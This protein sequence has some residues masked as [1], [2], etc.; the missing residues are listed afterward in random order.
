MTVPRGSDSP[1]YQGT[2]VK[3][4]ARIN[5]AARRAAT[6]AQLSS[7]NNQ[8]LLE[9]SDTALVLM[10]FSSIGQSTD[11]RARRVTIARFIAPKRL[12]NLLH[13]ARCDAADNHQ[14]RRGKP[15]LVRQLGN[16]G[17]S[18]SLPGTRGIRHDH[19]RQVV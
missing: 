15:F 17:P 13:L 18:N 10:V 4:P 5:K 6:T 14:C 3:T 2:R 11:G 1:C 9:F 16:V 8:V 12:G 19:A 7:D